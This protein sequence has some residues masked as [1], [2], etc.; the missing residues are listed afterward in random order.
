VGLEWGPLSLVR[1][2]EEPLEWKSICSAVEN[3]S[4]M[5]VRTRCADHAISS[6]PKSWQ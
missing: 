2:Y 5:A 4:L 1:I 3:P 6:T